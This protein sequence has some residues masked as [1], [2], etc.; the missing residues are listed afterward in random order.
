MDTN[1]QIA[2]EQEVMPARPTSPD[3][4]D[5]V[6]LALTLAGVFML[7]GWGLLSTNP[8]AQGLA[9]VGGILLPLG[10]LPALLRHRRR[11]MRRYGIRQARILGSL[12][13]LS[14]LGACG[15]V[16]FVS[17]QLP[18]LHHHVSFVG[19]SSEEAERVTAASSSALAIMWGG[20]AAMGVF[21]TLMILDMLHLQ[22][23]MRKR[24]SQ[25][26]TQI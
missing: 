3:R 17:L 11:T 24:R 18:R 14:I 15:T 6:L 12:G 21:M 1:P 9:T 8:R 16:A 7:G 2:I 4:F 26:T 19:L 10:A 13:Y 25:D 23:L 22:S 5:V 20:L